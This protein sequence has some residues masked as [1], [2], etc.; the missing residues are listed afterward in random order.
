MIDSISYRCHQIS[1]FISVKTHTTAFKIML[2]LASGYFAFWL[3][4]NLFI[5][6]AVSM[7]IYLISECLSKI[8][9]FIIGDLNPKFEFIPDPA[10]LKKELVKFKKNPNFLTWIKNPPTE[11]TEA[12][13]ELSN[14]IHKII[15]QYAAEL[16]H[17]DVRSFY[18]FDSSR[19]LHANFQQ[20]LK[21]LE[22]INDI[23]SDPIFNFRNYFYKTVK[24]KIFEMT[25]DEQVR[26]LSI[27]SPFSETFVRSQIWKVPERVEVL[28][29]SLKIQVA[30]G[31]QITL[32]NIIWLPDACTQSK[33]Y[34]HFTEDRWRA[35][36]QKTRALQYIKA[37]Q[38]WY[39]SSSTLQKEIP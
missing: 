34:E 18:S 35:G 37:G 8:S 26:E 9:L 1:T 22:E 25:A 17:D 32:N 21:F 16:S 23:S 31:K 3:G 20:I 24:V 12:L 2:G 30:E 33:G 4:S 5:A 19:W 7:G 36:F 6:S 29:N 10:A 28:I 11:L 38:L 14:P 15:S 13:P 27:E 39:E